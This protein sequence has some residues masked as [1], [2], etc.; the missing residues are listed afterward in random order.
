MCNSIRPA[1][2][3]AVGMIVATGFGALLLSAAQAAPPAGQTYVGVKAC[4]ACHLEQYMTWKK[5]KHGLSFEIVPAQYRTNATCL[6]CHSTGNGDPTGFK[7]EASTPN[8]AGN[9]CESCHGP[10]SAHAKVAQGFANKKTL[11]EAEQ[12]QVK[13]A[14]WR[15]QPENVC[16]RCHSAMA[17]KAHE[18]YEKAKNDGARSA[19]GAHS[20]N[21][22][23]R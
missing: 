20:S 12:K 11:S 14:I 7:D 15:M 4:A 3:T 19:G 5:S 18:T 6:K 16:A 21:P 10:G 8:L 1:K 17:H 2:L 23:Y 13:E 9:T 22:A